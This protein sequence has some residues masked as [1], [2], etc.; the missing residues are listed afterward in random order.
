M[1]AI[2][3]ALQLEGT[4]GVPGLDLPDL[5]LVSLARAMGIRRRDRAVLRR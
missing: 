1:R 5:G 4:P 3:T 2:A